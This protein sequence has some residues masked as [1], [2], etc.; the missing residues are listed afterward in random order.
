LEYEPLEALMTH[1]RE[2][3]PDL[4]VLLGPFVDAEQPRIKLGLV[5]QL[6]E[7]I[8][9]EGVRPCLLVVPDTHRPDSIQASCCGAH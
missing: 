8:F 2:A 4:L 7:D 9:Q 5:D 3:K 6:Y 1:C